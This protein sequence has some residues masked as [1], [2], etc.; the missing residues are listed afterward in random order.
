ML[1]DSLWEPSPDRAL[2]FAAR[3]EYQLDGLRREVDPVDISEVAFEDCDPIRGFPGWPGKRYYS[4]RLW[5]ARLDRQVEFE[6]LT[7]RRC[8]MELDRTAG[9]VSVSSQPMWIEWGGGL[10]GKHAPDYFVRSEDGTGTVVDVRPLARIDDKAQRQF[11]RTAEFCRS[12]G[13][14]YIVFAPESEIRDANLRFLLRYRDKAWV[15]GGPAESSSGSIA[16]IARELDTNGDGLALC[17][18]AI[19][20]GELVVD[21]EQPLSL[22]T[23]AR[24]REH[25]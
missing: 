2:A 1:T 24:W 14:E 9:V 7:E 25:L 19:W 21:L 15:V 16:E 13:W 20:A 22:R 8:L 12:A 3:V 4:G 23:V 18:A 17:Y 5:M 11:D 10:N 6:S